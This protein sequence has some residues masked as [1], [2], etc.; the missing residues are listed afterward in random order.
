MTTDLPHQW[1][2]ASGYAQVN[3]LTM[4][5]EIHG[6]GVPLVLLH[7]A[8]GT[9][10]SCFSN[11]LPALARTR[12]VIAVELQGHGHTP[13]IDRPLSY[14]QMAEDLAGLLH[15]LE[16][17]VAD[18]VGY[19]MGGAAGFQLALRHPSMVRRLVIAGGTCFRPEGLYPEMQPG[20]G[21]PTPED[22]AGSPWHQAYLEVAPDPAAWPTLVA[23]VGELDAGFAGWSADEVRS[24]AAPTLLMIGD[25]DIV[26]PEHTMEMFRLL[27]GGV[28]GDLVGLPDS[29][30]A[31]LPGTSHV[32][33]LERDDWLQSMIGGFLDPTRETSHDH[34]RDKP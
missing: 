26:R 24:L 30:L 5:Y 13:D 20:S 23:K 17:D 16:I 21:S 32:G 12:K 14:E 10:D 19:S 8:M 27:G 25:S 1:S 34:R 29:Q 6:T 28:A 11:L 3:E 7:G 18:F 4:Y 33:L 9:I 31:I 15:A 22:L 2:S